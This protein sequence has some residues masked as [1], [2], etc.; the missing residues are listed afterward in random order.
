MNSGKTVLIHSDLGEKLNRLAD[1][2][3]SYL[4][5]DGRQIPVVGQISLGRG[6]DNSIVLSDLR[7]PVV[8]GH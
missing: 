3:H 6:T 7:I 1:G 2:K 5:L 8:V 4:M